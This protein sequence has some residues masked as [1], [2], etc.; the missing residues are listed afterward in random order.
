[1]RKGEGMRRMRVWV[2]AGLSVVV[3]VL[4]GYAGFAALLSRWAVPGAPQATQGVEIQVC[5]NGVHT[6]LVLPTVTRAMDWTTEFPRLDLPGADA[7]TTH[8]AFGWGDRGFYLE[9]RRWSDLR[10]ATALAALFGGGSTVLHVTAL[11]SQEGNPDCAVLLLGDRQYAALVAHVRGTLKRDGQ[12][13]PLPLAGSGYGPTDLF[14]E[15]VGHYSP[16][17]TCN[18]WTAK[19]LRAAGVTVGRWTPFQGDVM[20]WLR[21]GG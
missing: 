14:Y 16:V 12:G 21:A 17:E 19:G 1:M 6:D 10:P 5:G 2:A 3:L 18:E 7:W 20:R 9:T 15:A 4:G 8:L 11:Y 13:R